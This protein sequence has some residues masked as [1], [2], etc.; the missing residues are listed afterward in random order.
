MGGTINL[1]FHLPHLGVLGPSAVMEFPNSCR[2]FPLLIGT[3]VHKKIVGS[4]R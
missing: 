1:G 4:K 2:D 3:P